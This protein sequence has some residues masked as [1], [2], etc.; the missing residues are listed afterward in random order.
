MA[1]TIMLHPIARQAIAMYTACTVGQGRGLEPTSGL[2]VLESGG[3]ARRVAHLLGA[4]FIT[5]AVRPTDDLEV[6]RF[7]VKAPER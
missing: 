7:H 4:L 2:R 1:M 6:G 3:V 5:E